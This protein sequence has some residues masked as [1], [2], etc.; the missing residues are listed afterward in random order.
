[1][2][3]LKEAVQQA[4]SPEVIQ[5]VHDIYDALG[6]AITARRPRCDA[7]GACC[8]F[9]QYGGA[10]GHRLYSTTAELAAF[11]DDLQTTPQVAPAAT[12][13]G[14]HPLPLLPDPGTCPYLHNSLCSVHA[15]RPFG[16]RIFFCDPTADDWMKDQYERHL[17]ALKALHLRF[18]IPYHYVEWRA[19]LQALGVQINSSPKSA[20]FA[21]LTSN[22]PHG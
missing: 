20:R 6:T 5:A 1:M 11:L 16:C 21:P 10:G 3:G 17:A 9:E 13:S 4:R 19:A 18:N 2:S 12:P 15:I 14:V 22:L 8:H 7:S